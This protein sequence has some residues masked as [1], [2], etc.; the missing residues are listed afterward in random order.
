M[1]GLL[2]RVKPRSMPH[3]GPK[4][5]QSAENRWRAFNGLV[6][7]PEVIDGVKFIDEVKQS[8]DAA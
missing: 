6:C 7:L 2:G 1:V 4:L 5:M 3:D 8:K